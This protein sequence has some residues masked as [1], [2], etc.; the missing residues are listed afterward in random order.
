MLFRFHSLCGERL[1]LY[2]NF[3]PSWLF[4]LLGLCFCSGDNSRSYFYLSLLNGIINVIIF[5]LVV[6]FLSNILWLIFINSHNF[7]I[8][9]CISMA[10]ICIFVHCCSHFLETVTVNLSYIYVWPGLSAIRSSRRGWQLII[11]IL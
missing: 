3:L 10:L 2:L 7:L 6:T 11:I 5:F 4:K 9:S 1:L 8:F